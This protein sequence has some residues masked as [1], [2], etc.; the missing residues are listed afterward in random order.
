MRFFFLVFAFF[1][2]TASAQSLDDA[3]SVPSDSQLAQLEAIITQTEAR[4]E[5]WQKSL[6]AAQDEELPEVV[7]ER[8]LAAI[9]VSLEQVQA[10][11]AGLRGE[12]AAVGQ[13][14]EMEKKRSDA[15]NA[16]LQKQ[17]NPLL[18][19]NG[20]V[21]GDRAQTEAQLAASQRHSQLLQRQKNA[22]V[23]A[24]ALAEQFH[25]ALEARY[26]RFNERYLESSRQ[27][28]TAKSRAADLAQ[29]ERQLA[30]L[31]EQLNSGSLSREARL[32]RYIELTLVHSQI[33]LTN[34]EDELLALEAR[35]Q[36]LQFADLTS[37]SLERIDRIR[38]ELDATLRR[39]AALQPQ[40]ESNRHIV[41][42]QYQLYERQRGTVPGTVAARRKALDAQFQRLTALLES[43]TT[44][45]KM[46]LD[47]ADRQYSQLARERLTEQYRFGGDLSALPQ[48]ATAIVKAGG[49]FLGQYAVALQTLY[50][51]LHTLSGTQWLLIAFAATLLPLATLGVIAVLNRL[52]RRYASQKKLT[53]AGRLLFFL[54]KMLKNNLPYLALFQFAL[55]LI[56]T[57]GIT[58][59]A[60][61]MLRLLPAVL[62]FNTI[63]YYAARNLISTGL[64]A[65]PEKRRIIRPTIIYAAVGSLLFSLVLMAGWILDDAVITDAYRWIFALYNLLVGIPVW[66]ATSRSLAYM[67]GFYQEYSTYRILRP[68]IRTIPAGILAFG[69]IGTLGYLNLAWLIAA[70]LLIFLLYALIWVAITAILKDSA[71]RAKRHA[72][73]TGRGVFWTQD[74]INPVH[75][76]LTY[77]SLLLILRLLQHSF[78][79]D[80]RTPVIQEILTLLKTPITKGDNSHFT[81]LNI[82]LMA[83]LLY[84]IYRVGGWIKSFSYRW[85]YNKIADLGIRNSLAVFSQY[86]AVTLGFFLALRVIGI[87]LT[88]FTV[89]AGALGVGIGFG[90]QT[91]AN[92][93]ISGILLLIER[94]LRNGDIIT[95]GN[96]EGTVERIGMRSLT[97]T[98][99]NNES[100]ILP[101][102]DFVT[103]AF[104]NWSHQDPITR[105]L[106]YLDL[107]YRHDPGYVKQLLTQTL[108]QLAEEDHILDSQEHDYGAFAYDYS[109]RGMTWRIQFHIHMQNHH[110]LTSRHL[111][112]ERIWQTCRAHGIEIAYP[113]QDL[114]FPQNPDQP[115]RQLRDWPEIPQLPGGKG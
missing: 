64:I 74:V 112:I 81:L 68:L 85:I 83:V 95:V 15:L 79:W 69:L 17:S 55:V 48:R 23:Q 35:L 18:R 113:K 111:V 4:N 84:I 19:G 58:A 31:G 7:G 12:Q 22:L 54:C 82:L 100:V 32:D 91:I 50:R 75:T 71:R 5:S 46:N 105:V 97:I 59:P 108:A 63:P 76:F 9:R 104:M 114:Y 47:I 28:P 87:D 60:S 99:F 61:N 43:N 24:V 96:Y 86:A 33:F 8:D 1:I 88:A 41:G 101:N 93:F 20:D 102:S 25:A 103:S 34:S 67:D 106:L 89:F 2:A 51:S 16:L 40:I 53:F 73:R 14:M 94:P 3:G 30:Q 62:L 13:A 44:S 107:G 56:H 37:L 115:A 49:T 21:H 66:R 29:L 45:L 92:N 27:A 70:H 39:F 110:R 90:M 26:Q 36:E 78:G 38:A 57:S 11:L 6:P 42:E 109:P 52:I 98:T 10:D 72:L 65:T 80:E 77:G